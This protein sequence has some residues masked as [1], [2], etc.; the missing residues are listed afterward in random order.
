VRGRLTPGVAKSQEL[1]KLM[2]AGAIDGL[3]IGFRTVR[4]RKNA[5]TGVRQHPRG[6]SLGDLDRHLSRCCPRRACRASRE[7]GRRGNANCS[8]LASVRLL[9]ELRAARSH[10]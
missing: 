2:R 6:G 9:A 10:A 5:A 1:L 3:S 4:A 8:R 7:S